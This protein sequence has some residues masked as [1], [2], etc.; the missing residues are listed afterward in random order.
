[1]PKAKAYSHSCQA[2][3]ITCIDFRIQEMIINWIKENIK[4]NFDRVAITG[5][6]RRLPFILDQISLSHKLHH[7]KEV[8]LINHED[9]GEYGKESTFENHKK[10]LL[11]ARK[12]IRDLI[13][14][15]KVHLYY[16]KM[17]GEFVKIH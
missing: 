7:T 16:L 4:G 6:A 5:S 15:F 3:V 8:Y 14:G 13:P 12:T 10:D 11:F 2:I 9:C 1:M 17:N